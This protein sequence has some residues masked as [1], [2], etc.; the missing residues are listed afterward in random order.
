[1]LFK[2]LKAYMFSILIG[3]FAAGIALL[4]VL[5][6]IKEAKDDAVKEKE[7]GD[8][9]RQ[10]L[11]KSDAIITLQEKNQIKQEA[12]QEEL[13]RKNDL[14]ISS[15]AKT[16]ELQE[17]LNEFVTGGNNMPVIKLEI[18][19]GLLS[20]AHPNYIKF[21]ALNKGRVP[22]STVKI[23][24]QDLSPPGGMY[25]NDYGD[26]P[27]Y[28][29]PT[30]IS[31]LLIEKEEM[32]YS[33]RVNSNTRFEYKLEVIWNANFY[34]MHLKFRINNNSFELVS[35]SYTRNGKPVDDPEKYLEFD[36]RHKMTPPY[37]PPKPF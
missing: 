3:V 11:L 23:K 9:N 1:M 15:Q 13:N 31:P 5:K 35:L 16:V 25:G 4:T 29:N 12:K 18:F 28:E 21:Y 14:L 27:I 26:T 19:K 24:V 32:F 6:E 22:I 7:I 20:P 34:D 17:Q 2:T 36:A 30:V 37:I 10:L 8:L 33:K